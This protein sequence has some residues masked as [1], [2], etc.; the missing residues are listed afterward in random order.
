MAAFPALAAA[1]T[2]SNLP[3]SKL[4]TLALACLAALALAA[5]QAQAPQEPA[6]PA[7]EPA[8]AGSAGYAAAHA[9]DYALVPLK[10]DLSRFDDASR[11]MIAKLVEASAV[12][13][14]IYWKQSWDG[15]RAALLA[16]A[17]DAATREL[18]EINYGPWDRLNEDT[19]FIDGIGPRPPGGRVLS[20]RHEQG[21]VRGRGT[22]RTRPPTTRCCAAR[23]AS[24]SACPTTRPTRPSSSAPPRCCARP[25][26]S[27]A[28]RP[29]ATT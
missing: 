8:K 12:M 26:R 15:D 29:S 14:D 22:G 23:A 5:C 3:S 17:P 4:R 28:T 9:G 19:P 10:A 1:M 7:A 6:Q 2:A 27:A 13:N 18:V 20:G 24:W 16:R 25:P 11:R 21:R